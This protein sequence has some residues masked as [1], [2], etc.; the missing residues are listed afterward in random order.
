[1]T[2]TQVAERGSRPQS[3]VA[4]YEGGEPRLDVV[5]F[6]DIAVVLGAGPCQMLSKSAFEKDSQ[7]V[8]C[9]IHRG[10]DQR[11]RPT[12]HAPEE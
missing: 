10:S 5:D 6:L 4:K 12:L 2:Q 7:G 8:C 1:M 11:D 9:V 3:F